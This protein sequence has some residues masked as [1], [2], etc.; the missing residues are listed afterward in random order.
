ML[1]LSFA[2]KA[3]K[4]SFLVFLATVF[5]SFAVEGNLL[6]PEDRRYLE[7]LGTLQVCVDPDWQPFES[8]D[9]QGQYHGIGADLMALVMRRLKLPFEVRRTKDWDESI[10]KSQGRNQTLCLQTS[11]D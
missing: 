3:M 10:A 5:L 2:K 6:T 11:Q 7:Q 8:L 1:V 9:A 4:S